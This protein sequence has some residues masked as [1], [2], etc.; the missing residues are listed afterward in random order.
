MVETFFF[1]QERAG[2][3]GK[4]IRIIKFKTLIKKNEQKKISKLGKYLRITRIDEIPQILNVIKG[5]ISFV[6]PRP[7]YLKYI[8]LYDK[9]QKR[10]LNMKPGITG[11]AQIN[12]DNNISWN[13]KFQLDIWY[14]DNFNIFIDIKIIFHTVFFFM[15]SIFFY[16]KI[17]KNKLV[18]DEEFNGKN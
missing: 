13:K 8:P 5:D 18:I 6:G 17:K 14:I 11:W 7:L 16:N 9:N 2:Y 3:M 4:K 1:V 15:R 12:G 10:R